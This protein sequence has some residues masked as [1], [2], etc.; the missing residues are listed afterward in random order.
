M[1]STAA[2]NFANKHM[3]KPPSFQDIIDMYH[4]RTD[5]DHFHPLAY[6]ASINPNIL[7]H[8]DAMKADDREKFEKAMQEEILTMIENEIFE[9]VPRSTV[10]PGHPILGGVWSHRRKTKPNG[11]VYRYRSRLCADGSRQK[12]GVD[13]TE[14]YAPVVS[15]TT[16]RILFIL[17]KVLGLESRQVD[18]VQAFPQATLSEGEDVY[19]S[20][21]AG[22]SVNGNKNDYVLKLKKNLYGLRQAAFNWNELLKAGL[23]QLGFKQSEHD[24]CL[25][26]K[27]NIV[28]VIYVDDTLF[29][30]KDQS[31]IDT[32]I[33]ALKGL[34][35]DLTDEG[36]VD[37]F[38][39]VKVDQQIDS[40]L[41]M[42]QPDLIQRII[43]LVGLDSSSK[44]HK[45]PA[46]SPPLHAHEHGAPR[47]ETWSYRSAIGMLL[48]LA[49][50]TRPDIEYA[51]HQCARFQINPKK[52]HENAVKRIA[53]YL[54]QTYDK[55]LVF[56]PDKDQM[57]NLQCY[58][59]A[60]FAGNY[61][62]EINQ[63]PESVK[64]RSGCV[65]KYANCPILWFSRMQTEIALSTT[66]AEYIALSTAAREVLPLR[67]LITE[68][69]NWTSLTNSNPTIHCTLFEDNV[70]AETLAKAPKMNPRTKHIA[71][72]YHHFR[73]AVRKG[74]LQIQ[75]VDTKDQ[76]ADIFTKP[77]PLSTF[78][79]LRKEIMG[80]LS[81][82]WRSSQATENEYEMKC[83]LAQ[84][85]KID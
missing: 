35:F 50:N 4:E 1:Y 43:A 75:R 62:K 60:D 73:E 54:K 8:R 5:Y 59:D 77:T 7:S 64:S 12:W 19:M 32:H 71:I 72:K 11:E 28:C 38:L 74:Y 76:L 21:P 58:V 53:R 68:L 61:T 45:T 2:K 17:S 44:M 9:E 14:S 57:D 31:I 13:F 33:D 84:I 51:V 24:P 85:V 82:Y 63:T 66:E 78:E 3:S 27:K 79:P 55:G 20:I 26:I 22:Y 67:E 39:G 49:K 15:W 56:K 41:K 65:I 23:L 40:S 16:V 80:W 34:D 37:A 6:A 29:F 83:N 70:G 25:Y 30:A 10:P 47:E 48:Y 36:D 42:S 69:T 46:I 81:L 52:A 18:Y